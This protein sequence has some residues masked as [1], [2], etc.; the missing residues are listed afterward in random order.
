MDPTQIQPREV[1]ALV[2]G[3]GRRSLMRLENI[4][5][6]LKFD[7]RDMRWLTGRD[8]RVVAQYNELLEKHCKEA[9]MFNRAVDLA[10]VASI[11]LS[12]AQAEEWEDLDRIVAAGMELAEKKCRKIRTGRISWTP[13]LSILCMWEKAWSLKINGRM[14]GDKSGFFSQVCRKA[15]IFIDKNTTMEESKEALA[16]VKRELARH[17][18]NHEPKRSFWLEEVAYAWAQWE[19]ELCNVVIEDIDQQQVYLAA[20][21]TNN[22]NTSFRSKNNVRQHASSRQ[23]TTSWQRKAVLKPSCARVPM[24][25]QLHVPTSRPWK[26]LSWRKDRRKGTKRGETFPDRSI[27]NGRRAT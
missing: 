15:G 3:A 1:V 20:T 2:E 6:D 13:E 16:Q 5:G 27:G 14:G 19:A 10:C 17:K 25:F 12:P 24:V 21:T 18:R 11:P 26:K 9:D 8:P 23:R 22:T 7:K 4:I